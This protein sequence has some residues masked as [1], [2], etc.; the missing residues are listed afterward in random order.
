MPFQTRNQL[1]GA[2]PSPAKTPSISQPQLS[3][4]R[5]LFGHNLPAA[6]EFDPP[7]DA[8]TLFPVNL[9]RLRTKLSRLDLTKADRE[10]AALK[11]QFRREDAELRAQGRGA[12][13]AARNRRL[14]GIKEGEKTRLVGFGGVRFE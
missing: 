9:R 7:S 12:E 5:R 13:I 6:M 11:E 3:F 4:V 2:A 10:V 1:T 8:A 14:M